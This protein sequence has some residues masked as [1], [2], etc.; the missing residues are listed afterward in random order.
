M[1]YVETTINQLIHPSKTYYPKT[2][3]STTLCEIRL[4]KTV[5]WEVSSQ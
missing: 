3:Q 4:K 2:N 1:P 5:T